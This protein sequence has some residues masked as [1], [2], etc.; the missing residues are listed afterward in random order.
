MGPYS[1]TMYINTVN[2]GFHGQHNQTKL[3]SVDME[4]R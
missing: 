3:L 1:R 2:L 4:M